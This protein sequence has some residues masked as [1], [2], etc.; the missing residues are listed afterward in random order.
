MCGLKPEPVFFSVRS[1]R[2]FIFVAGAIAVPKAGSE[3]TH[4]LL[5]SL[6]LIWD[7]NKEESVGAKLLLVCRFIPGCTG[8]LKNAL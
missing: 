4:E 2:H 7:A 6:G 5:H 8:C 3:T 1:L